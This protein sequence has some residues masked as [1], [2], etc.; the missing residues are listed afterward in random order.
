MAWIIRLLVLLAV[1]GPWPCA[2]AAQT[3]GGLVEVTFGWPAA[4]APQ[5]ILLPN[6]GTRLAAGSAMQASTQLTRPAAGER[7]YAVE[8]LY[9]D[10]TSYP[11][12]LR[13]LPISRPVTVQLSRTR[14]D[15]CSNL[16]LR[17]FEAPTVSTIGSI[18]AA[19]SVQFM[20]SR[21]TEAN[22]CASWPLR[23]QKALHDRYCNMM[24]LSEVLVVPRSIRD[25]FRTAAAGRAVFLNAITACER[26]EVRR[27]TIVLQAAA[28][29]KKAD[30][31]DAYIASAALSNEAAM[32][33]ADDAVDSE[34]VYSQIAR[35]ALEE[36][37]RDLREAASTRFGEA[38]VAAIDQSMMAEAGAPQ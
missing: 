38:A 22:S 20:L 9:P 19:F 21:E 1:I 24:T 14:P 33:E 35:P 27:K 23:A 30:P 15:S 3:P 11:L 37:T 29:D 31:R 5:Q 36:Q 2:A 16:N 8:I 4:D 25:Q 13:L 12:E 10:G 28:T 6:E 18:R 17:P 7:R 34:L 32:A 26:E